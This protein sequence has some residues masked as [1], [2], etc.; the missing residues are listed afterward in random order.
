[1]ITANRNMCFEKCRICWPMFPWSTWS[2]CAR[3]DLSR[4][5]RIDRLT[6]KFSAQIPIRNKLIQ[7]SEEKKRENRKRDCGQ[8]A[9]KTINYYYIVLCTTWKSTTW[10]HSPHELNFSI[11]FS[12]INQQRSNWHFAIKKNQTSA[13]L[14]LFLSSPFVS[15]HFEVVV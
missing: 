7:S 12:Y 3:N 10:P 2:C 1:M 13:W 9:N 15:S 14:R 11:Y 5:N 4:S 6:G 8:R